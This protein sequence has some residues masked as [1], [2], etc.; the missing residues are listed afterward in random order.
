MKKNIQNNNEE[1]ESLGLFKSKKEQDKQTTEKFVLK[2]SLSNIVDGLDTLSQSELKKIQNMI[3]KKKDFSDLNID[4][5]T[6]HDLEV[7]YTKIKKHKNSK[8]VTFRIENNMNDL[9]LH[10]SKKLGISKSE[11]TSISYILMHSFLKNNK[12]I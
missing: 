3:T 4:I 2:S 1:I 8:V 5:K 12:N 9:C 7:E 10:M 6:L 11:L